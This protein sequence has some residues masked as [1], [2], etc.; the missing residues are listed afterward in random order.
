[1]GRKWLCSVIEHI[2]DAPW[3]PYRLRRASYRDFTMRQVMSR[4]FPA[5]FPIA[6]HPVRHDL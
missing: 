3:L 4:G 2:R 5:D 6:V 1:M